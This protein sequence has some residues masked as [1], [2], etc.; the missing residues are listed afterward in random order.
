LLEWAA[1]MGSPC[2]VLGRRGRARSTAQHSTALC[3]N[4]RP[5]WLSYNKEGVVG[6]KDATGPVGPYG[7]LISW[8]LPALAVSIAIGFLAGRLDTRAYFLIDPFS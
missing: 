1:P 7:W 3:D 6:R 5:G 8:G 4:E 2:C